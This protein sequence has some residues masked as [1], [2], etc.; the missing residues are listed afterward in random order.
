[1][2]CKRTKAAPPAAFAVD[3]SFLTSGDNVLAVRGIDR[4]GADL[5]DLQVTANTSGVCSLSPFN[6]NLRIDPD[7]GVFYLNGGFKVSGGCSI[8]PRTQEVTFSVGDY[9]VTVPPGSFVKYKTGYV[10]EKKVNGI[11][12]CIYLKFTK[13]PGTYQLL[14]YR[15]GGTIDTNAS[16][17]PVSLSIDDV[18]GSADMIATFF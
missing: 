10:Y 15:K 12:L 6:G 17:V 18:N 3:P 13:T 1:M 16:P 8:D 5:L 2:G 11:F 7:A 4:G 14:V 9:S